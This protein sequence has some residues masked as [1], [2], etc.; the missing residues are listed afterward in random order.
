MSQNQLKWSVPI[1][2]AYGRPEGKMTVS[3]KLPAHLPPLHLEAAVHVATQ[4]VSNTM[5]LAG[6]IG[7]PDPQAISFTPAP[8][9]QAWGSTQSS[10]PQ[11]THWRSMTFDYNDCFRDTSGP[12]SKKKSRDKEAFNRLSMPK[13]KPPPS[14]EPPSP[15]L[16]PLAPSEAA[17]IQHLYYSEVEKR[18]QLKAAETAQEQA[19]LAKEHSGRLRPEQQKNLCNRIYAE[20]MAHKKEAIVRLMQQYDEPVHRLKLTREQQADCNKRLF[21]DTIAREKEVMEKLRAQYLGEVS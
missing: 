1:I 6:V 5:G 19:R 9:A 7:V 15:R 11:K 10:R 17:S 4:A 16:G 2:P 18:E 21:D 13:P 20:S 12:A 14:P 3:M 8:P